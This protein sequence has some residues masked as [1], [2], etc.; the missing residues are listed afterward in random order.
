[1]NYHF[2]IHKGIT[3]KLLCLFLT[4]CFSF[5]MSVFA[6]NR[7]VKGQVIDDSNQPIAG[8]N[9]M[10]KGTNVGTSTDVA[11]KYSISVSDASSKLVFS[12]VGK[13][14]V[15]K[16]IT[17]ETE[18]NIVLID[19]S[20]ELD[21]VIVTATSQPVRKIET[22][23]AVEVIGAKEIARTS[24]INLADAVRYV[25]GVFVH[26]GPGRTRNSIWMRGFPDNTNNGLVYTSLLA[27]GLRTFSSP[28]M[29]P[30]AAFRMDMNVEKIE[31]VRGSAATLY[32]RG[33]AAGAINVITKTGGV[34]HGGGMRLS[35]SDYNNLMQLDMNVNGPLNKS[36]TLR[37]NVGGFYLKDDGF[38]NNQY[39]DYGGQIRGNIDWILPNN[40]GSLRVYGGFINLSV[41]NQIDIPYLANDLSAPANGFTS[42][43][44]SL[45]ADG[46]K[47]R[48]FSIT[49]PNGNVETV[50]IERG[51][52]DG[53][54]SK[55]SN[56]GLK[57]NFNLGN[58][59]SLSNNGRYQLLTIGTQFDFPL[60]GN[61]G[62]V[63]QRAQFVG[64]QP[65]KGGSTGDDLI[66]EVRL[67]KTINLGNSTHSLTGGYYYSSV[68][69]NAAAIGYLYT[70][71]TD[72]AK[73]KIVR[74]YITP[75]P[76]DPTKDVYIP[77][78]FRNGVY[79]ES[80]NSF[81]IGDEAK[82]NDKLTVNAGIRSDVINLDLTEDRY[83]YQRYA[84]RAVEHKGTSWSLG[85]NYMFD[86]ST[87]LYA[88]IVGAYRAPDYS[89]YTTVQYAYRKITDPEGVKR[90]YNPNAAD[91]PK[92]AS[93]VVRVDAL[94]RTLYT[95]DY[96]DKNEQISS[97]EFGYRKSKG[98]LG[99][100][101]GIFLNNI[102]DRLVSTFIGGTAVQV[103]GGNNR[104]YGTELSLTYTPQSTKGLYARTSITY[105]KTSYSKL[106]QVNPLKP[107][108]NVDLSGNRVA[109]VPSLVWNLNIGYESKLGGFNINNNLTTGRPVDIYNTADYPT[110]SLMDANA[111]IKIGSFSKNPIRLK[112]SVFNLFNNQ[113]ASSVVSAQTDNSLF[114]ASQNQYSGNF[115]NVRGV[116]FLPRRFTF[117]LEIAF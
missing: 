95:N 55:G 72:D 99:F 45:P 56:I 49:Y 87:S 41:Q 58:G 3:P 30:D 101:G 12:F 22:V 27:D 19:N 14:S 115:K 33:A 5:S 43:D 63:Q 2:T 29:V 34:N 104:I 79:T 80:V 75:V 48:T 111:Y 7:V 76:T 26:S 98:D 13:Q 81:F 11:G 64:G 31:V 78:L 73:N 10:I 44:V 9:V 96:I 36:K 77:S 28:E 113:S 105:Q 37:Y 116:P 89:A 112:T 67:Q 66:N 70:L 46:L 90:L 97:Y 68:T 16:V 103:P 74:G 42:R 20:S 88:N 32:G 108:E 47:G 53:N 69:V 65:G 114:L 51:A 24:S 60:Q 86:R 91:F 35:T 106:V 25:P 6:Q 83:A 1:M 82:F 117:A 52:K 93:E 15:E 39:P 71:N 110:V 94:G 50:D 107:T 8:A 84:K 102:T 109:S 4:L 21:Q 38:R 59:F 57:F 40:G 62:S 23:T 18:I 61:F 17:N 100:D 54:F 92:V 85:F